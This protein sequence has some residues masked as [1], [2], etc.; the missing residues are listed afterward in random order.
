MI[1]VLKLPHFLIWSTLP[2][3]SIFWFW[4]FF[5]FPLTSSL[6]ASS[7][8]SQVN[9]HHHNAIIIVLLLQTATSSSSPSLSNRTA[10]SCRARH[11]LYLTTHHFVLLFLIPPPPPLLTCTF[12][13][14]LLYLTPPSSLFLSLSPSLF[15]SASFYSRHSLTSCRLFHSFYLLLLTEQKE[16]L[17]EGRKEGS[18]VKR[19]TGWVWE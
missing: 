9:Y 11:A 15:H 16:R 2:F 5:S 18:D 7:Q 1:S 4:F 17:H 19:G 10:V 8:P 12:L 14:P 3:P 6:R 13:S